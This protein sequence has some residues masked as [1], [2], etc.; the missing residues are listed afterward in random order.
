MKRGRKSAYDVKIFPRLEEIKA[1]CR[2]GLT[3]REI[4]KK[5]GTSHETFYKAKREKPEFAD[6]L[7]ETKEIADQKVE[8]SLYKRAIGFE[9]DEKKITDVNGVRTTTITRKIVIPDTTAQIFWLKNRKSKNWRDKHD[10]TTNDEPINNIKITIVN[11][12]DTGNE[13]VEGL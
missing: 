4:C 5:L 1:W 12:N 8:D 6:V 13:G 3:D 10:I 7:K 9:Y 2:Q 11:E